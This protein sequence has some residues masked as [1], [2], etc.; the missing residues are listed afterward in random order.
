M[1]ENN[2]FFSD[3]RF[4]ARE[5]FPHGIARSGDFS[6]A[7]AKL[8]EQ[9]GHAYQA[10]QQGLRAPVNDE[11]AQFVEV[12]KGNKSASTPHELVWQRFLDRTENRVKVSSFS[13]RTTKDEDLNDV[14][15]EEEW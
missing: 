4:T 12:F 2:A 14:S 10:L 6:L 1:N 15:E 11:E 3:Q 9:H 13:S 7:Q 8:L 5:C